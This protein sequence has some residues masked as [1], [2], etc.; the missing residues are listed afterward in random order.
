MLTVGSAGPDGLRDSFSNFG[1]YLDVVSPGNQLVLPTPR[2]TCAT[3]YGGASGTSF[4][5]PAV[6]G[7]TA[8][9]Q[10]ARPSLTT[11]QLFDLM[12]TGAVKAIG[13]GRSNDTGYGNL[14][15]AAGLGAK[16]PN[17]EPSELNDD[18]FWL[19]GAYRKRHPSL[20]RTTS[21][22]T[23][24]GSLSSEKDPQDVYPIDL[25]AGQRLTVRCATSGSDLV[26]LE[27]Y[28]PS[29]GVFDVTR[30]VDTALVAGSDGLADNPVVS[31]RARRGG[32]YYVAIVAPDAPSSSTADAQPTYATEISY[33]LSLL[34]RKVK[35]GK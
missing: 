10:A 4:S 11:Q 16:P 23:V 32:R 1:P 13:N 25:R 2:T 28:K 30:G 20:L 26:D 17:S 14:D 18:I 27:L 6:A 12:R 34:K 33:R 31:Y 8:W 24:Q 29:A 7:A 9:L 19:N 35:A 15:V 21:R 5:A 22:L 3:G